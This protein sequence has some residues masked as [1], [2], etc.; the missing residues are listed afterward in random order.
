M[1]A[2]ARRLGMGAVTEARTQTVDPALVEAFARDGF[3]HVKGLLSA[4]EIDAHRVHVDRAV[5][6]RTGEDDRPMDA[7][8]PFQQSFTMCPCIWEDF[9]DVAALTFHPKIAGTAAALIG[10][11]R[12]RLW[13]DQALYQEAGGRETA[14]HPDHP[15]S[16]VAE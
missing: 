15:Y 13:H 10:A 5:A 11:E 9:P 12:I 4:R 14:M 7:K 8:T 16:P 6:E 1:F 2:Q 3:V